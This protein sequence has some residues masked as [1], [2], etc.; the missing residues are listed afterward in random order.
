MPLMEAQKDYILRVEQT[1]Q[2]TVP[3]QDTKKVYSI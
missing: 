1:D 2:I 3:T